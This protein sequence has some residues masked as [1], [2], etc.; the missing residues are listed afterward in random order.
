[1]IVDLPDSTTS[2]VQRA[3][4]KIRQEGGAVAL[5]RVLTLVIATRSGREEEAIEAANDASREH[6]MRIIV[7]A[8]DD[9][10]AGRPA[11]LD[12]QIRV[13]GAA[14]ASEVVV[15]RA[16]G[17]AGADEEGLITGLLLPDAP[18]VAWW[19]GEAPPVVAESPI[20][21][22]AQR[23]ITDASAQ[24]DPQAAL[25]HLAETYRPGN[26][27]FAWTR[28]TLWR[29]LLAA[30]LDQPPFEPVVAAE[31]SGAASSPSTRL[32]AAWLGVQL[33]APVSYGLERGDGS[34]GIHGVRLLRP[35]GPIDL[36]RVVP[37]VATLSQ[38]G[39]PTHHVSLP[40]RSLRDCLAEELRR[41]DPDD[42]Y[43]RV[44]VQ[45]L[46]GLPAPSGVMQATTGGS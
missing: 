5:G 45:G 20:G 44:L 36:V 16:H 17:D 3:L 12:A 43:G 29:G 35:S 28:L 21:R 22:I 31:V 39:Q 27:D 25:L 37:N 24:P 42:L 15:L 7:V 4:V 8:K 1:V 26:T 13:G 40:R 33:K 6:P 19:P 30:V 14:G 41:L 34:T 32:L 10:P 46:P 2:K 23:R 38:P 18:V 9:D 11:R